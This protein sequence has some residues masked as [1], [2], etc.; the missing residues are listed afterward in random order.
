MCQNINIAYRDIV[1][2]KHGSRRLKWQTVVEKTRF[3]SVKTTISMV[4][5]DELNEVYKTI[6]LQVAYVVD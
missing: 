2:Q 6:S 1:L 4:V 5:D 3:M